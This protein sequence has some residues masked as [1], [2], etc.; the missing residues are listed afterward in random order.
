M[1]KDKNLLI[2]APE[3]RGIAAA[4]LE[5]RKAGD[6][7]TLVGYASVFNT[8]YE[9]R[10]GPP[11]GWNEVME[12]TAFDRTLAESPDVHLLV[13]H[14]GMPLARTKSGN[15]HL[16]KD[17]KGLK[18]RAEL[19]R[20]DPD[21][22]RLEPKMLRGDMDEMSFAFRVKAQEWNDDETERR[23]TEVSL[24]KGDVS[25]V[26][27]GANP[28]TSA[29]LRSLL[30]ALADV[31]VEGA[32]V[33]ARAIGVDRLAQAYTVLGKLL[34]GTKRGDAQRAADSEHDAYQLAAA[35]DSIIDQA[36]ALCDGMDMSTLPADMTQACY[37]I[38]AAD[39]VSDD[40]MEAMGIY[41]PD[42][43]ADPMDEPMAMNSL[44]ASNI[45]SREQRLALL[46]E[47]I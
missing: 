38:T 47:A 31:D 25:V 40:L 9:V 14:E 18:V 33:E 36:C 16:S 21:V 27:F 17:Q 28:A 30:S 37:L 42:E 45:L 39:S 22:Q 20:T 44:V 5:F 7:L 2:D 8:P 24:H 10:G 32:L 43:M 4:D 13:N 26:N 19:D 35:L 12:M 46:D 3:R 23:I 29:Q 41:D 11:W 15:L 6:T 34:R 1:I